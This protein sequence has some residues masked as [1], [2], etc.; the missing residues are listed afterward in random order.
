MIG[1]QLTT[2]TTFYE[3]AQVAGATLAVIVA[4]L[5][6]FMPYARR[7]RLSI[8]EDLGRSN[9]RV[10]ASGLGGLPHVRLLVSNA[11]G[12]RAA[13]G[14]RVL[15]E[16]YTPIAAHASTLT[17]LGHP[18]LEWPSASDADTGAVT[19]FGGGAHPDHARLLRSRSPRR[20]GR[21]SLHQQGRLRR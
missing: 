4:G 6:A 5:V 1:D 18:S 14:V 16:G 15:L 21:S 17:T 3:W 8:E 19:V 2:A 13:K 20:S 12:R 10:E 9:S 11:K 7:P